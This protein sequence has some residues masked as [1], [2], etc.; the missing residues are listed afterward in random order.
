MQLLGEKIY[1][2]LIHYPIR[3]KYD[4]LVVTSITNFDLHDI[5]RIGR[6]YCIR[7]LFIVNPLKTQLELASRICNFWREGFGS[8]SNPDRKE[9]FKLVKL[10]E[11][12]AET[13]YEI[14]T[15]FGLLPVLVATDAREITQSVSYERMKQMIKKDLRPFL[16]LF[17]TGWGLD[18][19]IVFAADYFLEPILG[20]DGWNHL[21][22]RA[23]VAIIL[24]RLLSKFSRK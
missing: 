7:K 18:K 23:A 10:N 5:A 17:G 9:A 19:E 2:A 12:L 8:K 11:N 22:V 4:D 1:L 13:I 24:D 3:G 21:P 16:L 15:E 14:K 20:I 6:T